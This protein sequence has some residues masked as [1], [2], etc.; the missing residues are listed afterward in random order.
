MG[1]LR[2]PGFQAIGVYL[3][4]LPRLSFLGGT[5]GNDIRNNRDDPLVELHMFTA[6]LSSESNQ[7]W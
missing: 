7:P 5:L 1:F 2:V 6:Q 4:E 3:G